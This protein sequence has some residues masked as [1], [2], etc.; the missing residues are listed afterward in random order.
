MV[1]ADAI[2]VPNAHIEMLK[3]SRQSD[4]DIVDSTLLATGGLDELAAGITTLPLSTDN[5]TGVSPF[6]EDE[7]AEETVPTSTTA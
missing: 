1:L 7:N 5:T 6:A 2:A 4:T 3:T